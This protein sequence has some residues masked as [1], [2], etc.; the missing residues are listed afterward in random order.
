MA[1]EKIDHIREIIAGMN[2]ARENIAPDQPN[3]EDL[4]LTNKINLGV[5]MIELIQNQCKDADIGSVVVSAIKVLASR[6]ALAAHENNSPDTGLVTIT[7]M[8]KLLVV[9][10]TGFIEY[11]NTKGKSK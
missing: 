2:R 4:D 10:Y 7:K 1:N 6:V 5:Q 3:E 9:E 8:A 11:L